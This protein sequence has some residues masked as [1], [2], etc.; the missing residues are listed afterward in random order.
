M[1]MRNLRNFLNNVSNYVL[2][3]KNLFEIINR[4]F[5]DSITILTIVVFEVFNF[6]ARRLIKFLSITSKFCQIF[7]L[8]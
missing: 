6:C 1:S 8:L 7:F 3:S 5:D 2:S 4:F